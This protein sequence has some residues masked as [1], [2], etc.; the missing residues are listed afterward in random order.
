MSTLFF[1]FY[2]RVVWKGYRET[3]IQCLFLY[4]YLKNYF[5][6]L[7]PIWEHQRISFI[8]SDIFFK[9]SSL[10]YIQ[11]QEN[12]SWNQ[13]LTGLFFEKVWVVH[14]KTDRELC[15]DLLCWIIW[16]STTLFSHQSFNLCKTR[17]TVII[18]AIITNLR[19]NDRQNLILRYIY[20]WG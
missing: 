19:F 11:Y 7:Q 17:R 12:I 8:S 18:L 20:I 2:P 13:K 5:F 15:H 6:H 9:A 3:S 16:N 14:A 4:L 1:W 10:T